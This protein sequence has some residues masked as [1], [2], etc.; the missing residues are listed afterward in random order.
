VAKPSNFLAFIDD[1]STPGGE[2]VFAGHIATTDAWAKFKSE[3]EAML[4]FGTLAENG[5]QHFKMSEMAALPERMERVPWFYKIIEDHVTL[6]LACR[7]S[8][9]D[10]ETALERSHQCA[11]A[12]FAICVL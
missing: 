2:S 5:K 1:S 11:E 3:W 10:Y 7:I 12:R 4:P 6:S 8:L 9:A